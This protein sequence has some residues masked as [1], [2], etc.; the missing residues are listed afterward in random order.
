MQK[1]IIWGENIN[2]RFK[3]VSFFVKL[4]MYFYK[5]KNMFK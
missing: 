1:E 2:I 5:Y 3:K 4:F